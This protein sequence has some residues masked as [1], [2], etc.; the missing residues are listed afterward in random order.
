MAKSKRYAKAVLLNLTEKQYNSIVEIS[1]LTDVDITS[2][3]RL[4][5]NRFCNRILLG[6]DPID[7]LCDGIEFPRK[8]I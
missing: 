4:S 8:E 2:L 7:E 3:I 1:K 6:R 5:I